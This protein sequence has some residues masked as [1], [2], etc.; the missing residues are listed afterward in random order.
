M[1][2]SHG[3]VNHYHWREEVLENAL[4]HSFILDRLLVAF[5]SV[6]TK[7]LQSMIRRIKSQAFEVSVDRSCTQELFTFERTIVQEILDVFSPEE[8]VVITA[9]ELSLELARDFVH[10]TSKED[11]R[12]PIEKLVALF[13]KKPT[14]G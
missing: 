11:L 5:P 6:E 13:V 12:A 4:L 14:K 2:P 1:F 9:Q 10:A 3:Y 7:R 8:I